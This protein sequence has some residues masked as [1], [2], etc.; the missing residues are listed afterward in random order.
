M[1]FEWNRKKGDPKG[2]PSHNHNKKYQFE[3]TRA[4]VQFLVAEPLVFAG[5]YKSQKPSIWKE[6]GS[7]NLQIDIGMLLNKP[8]FHPFDEPKLRDDAETEDYKR[9]RDVG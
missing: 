7:F 4:S 3:A 8:V 2:N 6:R 1:L 5:P 9:Q